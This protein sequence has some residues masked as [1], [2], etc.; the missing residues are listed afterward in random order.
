MCKHWFVLKFAIQRKRGEL[1]LEKLV[2]LLSHSDLSLFQNEP[3]QQIGIP[4]ELKAFQ[5]LKFTNEDT[6]IIFK[7]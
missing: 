1:K 4:R 5:K 7:V 2:Y 6:K 3:E